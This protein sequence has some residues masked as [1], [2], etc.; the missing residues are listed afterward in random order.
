[1]KFAIA[2][3]HRD[4]FQKNNWIEFENFLTSAQVAQLNQAINQVLVKRLNIDL[5]HLRLA[6]PDSCY[7]QGRDLWR[8]NP[9]IQELTCYPRFAEIAS[10]LVEKKPLRLG[11]DQ[12][13]P[14]RSED[15]KIPLKSSE[16]YKQFLQQT[17]S[18]ESVS[19]IQGL[20]CGLMISLG[21]PTD[22]EIQKSEKIDI[23]PTKAGNAIFF[24]PQLLVD[25]HTL[26]Q[27]PDQRYYL[28]TYAQALSFYQLQP[29]DPHTHAL[30][31]LGYIFN[32]KLSD[33]LN[34]ILF[35]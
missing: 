8:A 3:E 13:F 6:S 35:R 32:D 16:V 2:K 12:L 25:W 9:K 31:H 34:P 17:T 27:H 15:L 26:Y 7:L 23:F 28:I 22:Q 33:K 18:L 10:E 20:K 14:S 19:C 24:Q 29:Q 11:Y 1:M 30:K 4:F 21:K 5:E